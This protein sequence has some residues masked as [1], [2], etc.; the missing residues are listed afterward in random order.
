[1]EDA[2]FSL[3]LDVNSDGAVMTRKSPSKDNGDGDG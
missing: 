3:V 2:V 1:M